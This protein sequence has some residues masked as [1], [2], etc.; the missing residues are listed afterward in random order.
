MAMTQVRNK[1]ELRSAL[2]RVRKD[3]EGMRFA[4]A[5][6]RHLYT[7]EMN[8]KFQEALEDALEEV[9]DLVKKDIEDLT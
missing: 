6:E 9:K 8:P 4:L 7:T 3:I 2:A 5:F 1:R